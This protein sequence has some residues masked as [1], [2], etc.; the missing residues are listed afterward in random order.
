MKVKDIVTDKA[1][2]ESKCHS[3]CGGKTTAKQSPDSRLVSA[4]WMSRKGRRSDGLPCI[5]FDHIEDE[6]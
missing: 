4:D 3:N 2:F 6:R 5:E 1:S